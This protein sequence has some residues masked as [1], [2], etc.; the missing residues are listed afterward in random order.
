MNHSMMN[1]VMSLPAQM[2]P[3]SRKTDEWKKN[4]ADRLEQIGRYQLYNNLSLVENYEIIKGK[5]IFH[6]YFETSGYEDMLHNLTQEFEL[7][8]Y[9]R[10]YD[11]ISQVVN[12]LSGEYQK[13]PDNF[14]VRGTDEVTKSQFMRDKSRMLL[15]YIMEEING[16]IDIQLTD[17]GYELNKTDFTSEEEAQQ[18]QQELSQRRQSLT[19]PEVEKYMS[20]NYST[21]AEKWGQAHLKQSKLKY[22]LMEKEIREFEDMLTSDRCFRHF[23][24]KGDDYDQETWNPINTFFHVSPELENSEDGDY[25]GRMIYLTP[26]AIIDRWGWRMK[27]SDLAKIKAA[28]DV[29][30]SK[31]KIGNGLMKVQD[32]SIIP[33]KNY[34]DFKALSDASG[35]DLMS[36]Q[37]LPHG[38]LDNLL[39]G[40]MRM[41]N[42]AGYW[43]VT[44][45]YYKSMK[46]IGKVIYI[47]PETGELQKTLVDER[48]VMPSNFRE[49]N[50]SIYDSDEPN[51]V[52]WTWVNEVRDCIKINPLFSE[53]KNC[54]YLGGDPIPFQFKAD[55]NPYGVKLPVCGGIFNNRNGQSA[56]LV[57]MMK[58][59]QIGYNVAVNQLYQIQEREI[60]RFLLLDVNVLPNWKDWGGQAGFEKFIMAGKGLSAVPIDTSATNTQGAS[61]AGGHFS[62]MVDL[63][64]SSRMLSR[65]NI[66]TWFEQRALSQVGITPQRLG[67]TSA[68]ESA[69]GVQQAVS[70][71]YAQTESH[72]TRFSNYKKRCLT[73]DLNIGQYV[74][75]K[76]ESVVVQ[77]TNDD[78]SRGFLQITGTE[79]ALA[80]LGVFITDSQEDLRQLESIRQLALE[81]NTTG[82]TIVDLADIIMLNS[83]QAIR[84]Q[85][86]SSLKKQQAME[87]QAQQIE[88]QKLSQA[89]ELQAA[90]QQFEAEQNQLDR[91]S[92]EQVAYINTFR[93]KD[94]T[95]TTDTDANGVLDVLEYDKFNESSRQNTRKMDLQAQKQQYEQ[96]RD[97]KK[98]QLEREKIAQKERIEANKLK[99]AKE[100]KNKY[101]K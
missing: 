21:V 100:N 8:K 9:L 65:M 4:V 49:V 60:G 30:D 44:E 48:F 3:L 101:D 39:N 12:V 33:F 27:K 67:T 79:L 80:D 54:I 97:L 45:A 72:F 14:R 46:R 25:V 59:H 10:H 13:R 1:P 73:M 6:H 16:S 89:Q 56:S 95:N 43:Q 74:A 36:P 11:I 42:L 92:R 57:D 40:S 17:E 70:Q 26:S 18:Y 87:Q 94:N 82:A 22:N 64:E 32:G 24:L 88:Q 47:D 55:Y 76:K 91:E 93:G 98:D 7:P 83:P 23:Y 81:N 90:Q 58:P 28:V 19:P 85:L 41:I 75:S 86:D 52:V 5:F 68:S 99:V 77:Y 69:T 35:I 2:V 66:A 51:T 84:S 50:S 96:Q 31:S 53:E 34:E 62:S 71:S 63:D 29:F 37:T 38:S 20:M 78:M 15:Q 61:V